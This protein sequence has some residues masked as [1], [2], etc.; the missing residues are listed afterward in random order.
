MNSNGSFPTVLLLAALP[1]LLAFAHDTCSEHSCHVNEAHSEL[2][3]HDDNIRKYEQQAQNLPNGGD[4]NME[5]TSAVKP[6]ADG[7]LGKFND[8]HDKLE[9]SETGDSLQDNEEESVAEFPPLSRITPGEVGEIVDIELEDGKM[10]QRIT[11]AVNPPVYEIPDYLTELECELIVKLAQYT[12][13]MRSGVVGADIE[14]EFI[15]ETL[16]LTKITRLSDQT[17]LSREEMPPV[18]WE[19]LTNRLSRLTELPSSILEVSEPIQVV[20]YSGGGHYHAHLD[21]AKT[22]DS[23]HLPCCL[24]AP[25]CFDVDISTEEFEDCCRI[26]RYVTVLYYLNDVVEGGETAFPLADASDEIVRE[27]SKD[28][29]F[30]PWMD[31]SHYCHNASLVVKPKRG[32]AV[33]WYNHL[34]DPETGYLGDTDLRSYHGGCDIIKGN[35]WIANNWITATPYRDRRKPFPAN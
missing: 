19:N 13:L 7:I 30:E 31:L 12:G 21:T 34:M 14:E 26:C 27:R 9:D 28:T 1:F 25:E 23:G 20:S 2:S 32:T 15:N 33:M 5:D 22:S 3:G 16:D 24:Q 18:L 4:Y 17:W 10:Y 35:K 11:R 6:E 8:V 29:E